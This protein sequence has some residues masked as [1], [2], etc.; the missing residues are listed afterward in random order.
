MAGRGLAL[1]CFIFSIFLTILMH[2]F[3][4]RETA[5]MAPIITVA[6]NGRNDDEGC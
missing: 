6:P 1:V 2:F 4:K 3:K 5:Y